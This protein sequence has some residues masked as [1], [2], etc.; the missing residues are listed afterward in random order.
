MLPLGIL[1]DLPEFLRSIRAAWS[2]SKD[3]ASEFRSQGGYWYPTQ[4]LE[5]DLEGLQKDRPYFTMGEG[6]TIS[7]GIV[8]AYKSVP[9]PTV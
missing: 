2:G 7:M 4:D 8:I 9:L 1:G 6:A 5:Q 3:P